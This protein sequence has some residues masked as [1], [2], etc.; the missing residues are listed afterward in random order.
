MNTYNS[1]LQ[2]NNTTI[3]ELIDLA[4]SLPEAGSTLDTLDNPGTAEDL[5]ANKELL[6][7]EGKKVTGTFSLDSELATNTDLISQIT[8][9]LEGKAAGGG[10]NVETC[11]VEISGQPETGSAYYSNGLEL[12]RHSG[13][14]YP[15]DILT[16]AKNSIII[17]FTGSM[18]LLND[19]SITN[20]EVLY[21][22]EFGEMAAVA[23]YGDGIMSIY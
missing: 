2:T 20:G 11:T 14:F 1:K 17:I 13:S 12:V 15:G 18:A 3:Q 9:A 23:V 19:I 22:N 4:N 16:V 10:G 6:D 21:F 8:T 5:M 7:A